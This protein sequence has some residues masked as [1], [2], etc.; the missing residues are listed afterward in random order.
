MHT[1]EQYAD[2]VAL[3]THKVGTQEIPLKCSVS[4][5]LTTYKLPGCLL[6]TSEN[7]PLQTVQDSNGNPM[8]FSVMK[9]KSNL[10]LIRHIEESAGTEDK[11]TNF[12]WLVVN[13]TPT[14][15]A[16]IKTFTVSQNRKGDINIAIAMGDDEKQTIYIS[17]PL[18]NDVKQASDW[19]EINWITR[20]DDKEHQITNLYLG[21]NDDG[22][23][24]PLLIA[25]TNDDEGADRAQH[26]K[27]ETDPNSSSGL[28]KHFAI[29]EDT[30]E[31]L[32][33]VVGSTSRGRGVYT[34]YRSAGKLRTAFNSLPDRHG[35][36]HQ[37]GI[38]TPED[39]YCL[40][41]LPGGKY[42]FTDLFIGGKRVNQLPSKFQSSRYK[43]EDYLIPV[44]FET[45]EGKIK[46]LIVRDDDH[47]IAIW[48]LDEH[49]NLYYTSKVKEPYTIQEELTVW[50]P[51]QPIEAFE[52]ATSEEEEVRLFTM[53][54][55]NE[56]IPWETALVI[57]KGAEKLAPIRNRSLRTN[58]ILLKANENELLQMVQSPEDK[59]WSSNP[60]PLPDDGKIREADAY[61]VN[62]NLINED[63]S[64]F[65]PK[66]DE[67]RPGGSDK[68]KI[69]FNLSAS[70]LIDLEINGL[71][72]TVSSEKSV[73]VGPD[74]F[75]NI[76]IVCKTDSMA[77]VFLYLDGDGLQKRMIINPGQKV[78]DE[79]KKVKNANDLLNAKTSDG[80][81]L[82][83]K[84][85]LRNTGAAIKYIGKIH[86]VTEE[87]PKSGSFS[88]NYLNDEKQAQ[89]EAF[90]LSF[91]PE[92][93]LKS[94]S[95]D[96]ALQHMNQCIAED[97]PHLFSTNDLRKTALSNSLY[98]LEN[99]T[100][101]W[102]WNAFKKT[103]GDVIAWCK[104]KLKEA[105]D[106]II[107]AA[108]GVWQIAVKIA[109]E[110]FRFTVNCLKQAYEALDWL[111]K[112]TLGIDISK[113]I[114]WIGAFFDWKDIL[115]TQKAM[116]IGINHVIEHSKTKIATAKDELSDFLK[117]GTDYFK[118]IRNQIKD[119]DIIK[120][121]FQEQMDKQESSAD[122]KVKKGLALSMGG[123]GGGYANHLIQSSGLI[124]DKKVMGFESHLTSHLDLSGTAGQDSPEQKIAKF[125]ETQV[126]EHLNTTSDIAKRF[127]EDFLEIFEKGKSFDEILTLLLSSTAIGM[128]ETS[129]NIITG[130]MELVDIVI[131]IIQSILNKPIN[132]PFL[133]PLWESLTDEKLTF[134]NAIALIF[135]IPTTF[136]YK[137][138]KGKAPYPNGVDEL[139]KMSNAEFVGYFQKIQASDLSDDDLVSDNDM[140]MVIKIYHWTGDLFNAIAQHF[141]ASLETALGLAD[142]T[143]PGAISAPF[144]FI[145]IAST[146]PLGKWTKANLLGWVPSWVSLIFTIYKVVSSTFPPQIGAV[147]KIL[148]MGIIKF[149]LQTCYSIHKL[150]SSIKDPVQIGHQIAKL[151]ANSASSLGWLF[152]GTAG[153]FTHD[154]QVSSATKLACIGI[155]GTSFTFGAFINVLD[156]GTQIITDNIAVTD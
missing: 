144:N 15:E 27:V 106:C 112:H 9:G 95:G 139:E 138:L 44:P 81:D 77:S 17:E 28:W 114:K 94:Y 121:S 108:E 67:L 73:P 30:Q 49:K 37:I 150:A 84:E 78:Q 89:H 152:S 46:E 64:T 25:A 96:E 2:Q 135:A 19:N 109:G 136:I 36:S 72:V 100:D 62:L 32:S 113:L 53:D 29:P 38:F 26:Y 132:I 147:L 101:D 142:M 68:K 125:F 35:Q 120:Q 126:K 42:G 50:D 54:N 52:Y 11:P 58:M 12:G 23:G 153:L 118:D 41:S 151:F 5:D 45:T 48:F 7:H 65:Y 128:L 149:V 43:Q 59:L 97:A 34:L 22:K 70:A 4:S 133:T 18:S 40:A 116:V 137:L 119:D 124:Q 55:S 56:S 10:S 6:D 74:D 90:S 33:M 130:I 99:V 31:I 143:L 103:A 156:S 127:V 92:E 13:L 140:P 39:A 110:V 14:I 91:K 146:V 1:Q 63:G 148:I 98:D 60:I 76:R 86:E 21:T 141:K 88:T 107:K 66:S 93:G 122:P 57:Q 129:N 87:L 75:G 61:V 47:N 69:K 71:G 80:S 145:A 85:H 123:A 79:L 115:N 102:F 111:L 83:D 131:S 82:V 3:I 154:G 16:R 155:S 20:G 8:I 51:N 105:F 24:A 134:L 117:T 104:T